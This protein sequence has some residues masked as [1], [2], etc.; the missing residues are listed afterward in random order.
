MLVITPACDCS[1]SCRPFWLSS[2]S[3]DIEL[4]A[5]WCRIPP[6]RRASLAKEDRLEDSG[7]GG[8]SLFPLS[9]LLL[10]NNERPP[11]DCRADLSLEN[12]VEEASTGLFARLVRSGCRR[13]GAVEDTH[14]RSH[15]SVLLLWI[16]CAST[17]SCSPPPLYT[18]CPRFLLLRGNNKAA[19]ACTLANRMR[20]VHKPTPAGSQALSL[21]LPTRA[22]VDAQPQRKSNT[23]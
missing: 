7:M 17:R 6:A 18:T 11:L 4:R 13:V 10:P 1:G 5:E 15:Y 3:V 23:L 16:R 20:K 22:A 12:M 14:A 2:S 21:V 9:F 8:A 19:A